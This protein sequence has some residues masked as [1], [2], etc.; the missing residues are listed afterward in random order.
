MGAT[1][2]S[3]R[4]SRR[5]PFHGALLR[6]R[7]Q[8]LLQL[9]EILLPTLRRDAFGEAC[10][11]DEEQLHRLAPGGD[12]YYRVVYYHVVYVSSPEE[13]LPITPRDSE[14]TGDARH[15]EKSHMVEPGVTRLD[16]CS[17][18]HTHLN[19]GASHAQLRTSSTDRT[20]PRDPAPGER[21]PAGTVRNPLASGTRAGGEVRSCAWEA[22]PFRCVWKMLH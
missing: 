16:G 3:A 7:Q 8:F 6:V 14:A 9:P 18:F 4:C 19:G 20:P 22:P 2:A 1:A 5:P 21:R 15:E 11:L 17:I 10:G 13:V 12:I